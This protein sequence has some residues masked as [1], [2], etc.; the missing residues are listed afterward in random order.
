MSPGPPRLER[1]LGDFARARLSPLAA[2]R[3]IFVLKQGWAALFG[4]RLRVAIIASKLVWQPD[5]PLHRSDAL[6]IF[7]L[8]TQGLFLRFRLETWE[9]ARLIVLFHLPDNRPGPVRGTPADPCPQPRLVPPP[10]SCALDADAAGGAVVGL[11]AAGGG[12]HRHRDRDLALF[13]P[14]AASHGQ[15]CHARV[16]VYVAVRGFRHRH[17]CQPGSADAKTVQTR[18]RH[19]TTTSTSSTTASRLNAAPEAMLI[20]SDLRRS[21]A[22]TPPRCFRQ[23]S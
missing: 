7:A 23:M 6:L 9:E 2:E 18:P 12:N 4:G 8:V 13:R 20:S 22:G 21:P 11:R 10:P 14:E 16:L 1:R 15:S 3:V 17:P 5:W 19:Q